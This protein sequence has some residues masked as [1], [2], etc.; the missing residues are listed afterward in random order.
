MSW[1]AELFSSDRP[2]QIRSFVGA[3]PSNVMTQVTCWMISWKK[4]Y[5]RV[6]GLGNFLNFLECSRLIRR[7]RLPRFSKRQV[8]ESLF[9]LKDPKRFQRWLN[10]P[11]FPNILQTLQDIPDIMM[12]LNPH[13][14]WA[15]MSWMDSW[16]WGR[17]CLADGSRTKYLLHKVH[18]TASW[19]L[20]YWSKSGLTNSL[21]WKCFETI[22][23][24]CEIAENS[25]KTIHSR[26]TP[27][28]C[29]FDLFVTFMRAL[30]RWWILKI[31]IF[32]EE[33]DNLWYLILY[34]MHMT[35][36][37]TRKFWNFLS[38]TIECSMIPRKWP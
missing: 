33:K 1:R 22:S 27:W 31:S 24:C 10:V 23:Y 5:L 21:Q 35:L 37:Q 32:E 14:S 34:K 25:K 13:Q 3:I 7:K 6:F 11:S 9:D 15:D 29:N 18:F 26:I 36:T 12:K 38:I 8:S 30:K 2:S 16:H 19:N 17:N 20:T 28:I 4:S